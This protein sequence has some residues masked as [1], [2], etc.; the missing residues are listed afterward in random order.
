MRVNIIHSIDYGALYFEGGSDGSE[1]EIAIHAGAVYSDGVDLQ[2]EIDQLRDDINGIYSRLNSSPD[3]SNEYQSND[4]YSE[5]ENNS[6]SAQYSA[7]E[8]HEP[9]HH[10]PKHH[11]PKHHRR[12]HK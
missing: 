11:E 6:E 4:N 7:P 1:K 3:S 12:G 5:P 9:E 2:K 8:H 10:E